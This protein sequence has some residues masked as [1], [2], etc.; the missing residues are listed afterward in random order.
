[1]YGGMRFDQRSA[2]KSSHM[3]ASKTITLLSDG[4]CSIISFQGAGP[5][6]GPQESESSR[7]SELFGLAAPVL[8]I[9]Q[10]SKWWDIKHK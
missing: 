6:D 1:M 10:L 7:H 9:V 4:N 5:A 8:I 2:L 3:V